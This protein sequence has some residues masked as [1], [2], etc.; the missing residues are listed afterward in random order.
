MNFIFNMA[1]YNQSSEAISDAI[2]SLMETMHF[3]LASKKIRIQMQHSPPKALLDQGL[4]LRSFLVSPNKNNW[5]VIYPSTGWVSEM[6]TVSRQ[7]SDALQ[8]ISLFIVQDDSEGWGYELSKEGQLIDLFHTLPLESAGYL[9]KREAL[10]E[11]GIDVSNFTLNPADY[12]G[13]PALIAELFKVD[14]ATVR[15]HLAK[16][17]ANPGMLSHLE[18]GK[19][20]YDV[21]GIDK[22]GWGHDQVRDREAHADADGW[23]HLVFVRQMTSAEKDWRRQPR[24]SYSS[25]SPPLWLSE[26]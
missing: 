13:N 12:M 20:L 14:E 26:L 6:Q 9:E 11:L 25:I 3:N 24:N 5:C 19:L 7:L 17:R 23:I 1:V 2:L 22:W 15:E 4:M 18:M 10:E 8:C 16:S 21:L